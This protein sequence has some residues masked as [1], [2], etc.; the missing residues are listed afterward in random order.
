MSDENDE[1]YLLYLEESQEHL[2]DIESDLLEIEAQGEDLDDDLINRVFR[3]VHTVKGGAG[4]F[5]LTK[6]QSLAHIMENVLG[7]V[8]SKEVVVNSAMISAL[9]DGADKLKNMVNNPDIM[10][11]IE[12][13]DTIK[14]IENS[15]NADSGNSTEST[16]I[17]EEANST[18]STTIVFENDV[19]SVRVDNNEIFNMSKDAI[20]ASQRASTGG[21]FLYLV[22]Y[23]VK[24]D[25]ENKGK[26]L[27][28]VLKEYEILTD[29][30]DTYVETKELGTLESG[31]LESGTLESGTLE[32][33]TSQPITL[34][35]LFTTVMDSMILSEFAGV[36]EDK[37]NIVLEEWVKSNEDKTIEE[38]DIIVKEQQELGTPKEKSVGNEPQKS[39]SSEVTK[40]DVSPAA[41]ETPRSIK[42]D[43][44][45]ST[46]DPA[47]G[48]KKKKSSS[49]VRIPIGQLEVLMSLAGEL[50]LTRNELLQK[51]QKVESAN[52]HEIAQKVDSITSELQEAIMVTRMQSVDIVFNKF[53][54]VVRDLSSSLGKEIKLEIT[55]GDVEL[56][57]SIVEVI[58]DPLT[59]MVRNSID[60]GIEMPDVREANGKPREGTL[61]LS[62]MHKAG[63]VVISIKDDGG[64]IDPNKIGDIALSKGIITEE[65]RKTMTDKNLIMLI[66]KPGFSTAEKVTDLSGRGV[67]MDV[68]LSSFS[69][70]GGVVDIESEVGK[71]TEITIKLP[72]TLAIIPSLLIQVN[73]DRFAIPQVNVK[74]LVRIRAE[75]VKNRLEWVGNAAVLRLRGELLPVVRLSELLE[76][77]HYY[78]DKETGELKEDRRNRIVDRR[79]LSENE[80]PKEDEEKL[81]ERNNGRRKSKES[82]LNIVIVNAGSSNYGIVVDVLLDSEEI[83][84]KPLGTH[85]KGVKYYAGATILGDGHVAMI[86]DVASIYKNSIISSTIEKFDNKKEN[87]ESK[88]TDKEI[89]LLFRN[90][91]TNFSLP[92]I[93]IKRIEKVKKDDFVTIGNRR[94]IKY[95]GDT[96]VTLQI[97]DLCTVGEIGEQENYNVIIYQIGDREVGLVVGEVDDTITFNGN[98]DGETYVQPGIMGTFLNNNTIYYLVDFYELCRNLIPELVPGL[99]DSEVDTTKKILLVEDSKFFLDQITT[100][101]EG[102]GYSVITAMDGKEGIEK[103]DANSESIGM[104]VTD[105]EMPVMDGLEMV[106]AIREDGNYNDLPI[107]AVTSVAGEEAEKKGLEAGIDRYLIKM[108]KEQLLDTCVKFFNKKRG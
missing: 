101:L 98:F 74:E 15:L 16:A 40:K 78:Q 68:V 75:E 70:V 100:L 21:K 45:P 44:S 38:Q 25:I 59:H 48:E 22:E 37:I 30:I 53:K 33:G 83:V 1:V 60:H 32:S 107:I 41:T 24:E 71:G 18:E 95:R 4:F 89:L 63:Q 62:A 3:A 72:L 34:I 6:I 90:G 105:I 14:E 66:F 58:G 104:I 65:E 93:L 54:R 26:N 9:L 61:Q 106:K 92:M 10:D 31:T 39:Q 12:V 96:L 29:V 77:P 94:A 46:N 56:D 50:V 87:E 7:K 86:L 27:Q 8:R 69:K 79:T 17:N 49:T 43:T 102:V 81:R 23:D 82:A 88:K 35:L 99:S 47:N 67:G 55:G 19:L 51:V 64:G 97:D 13:D 80:V 28:D 85:L 2:E 84:V 36:A 73:N 42:K 5:S 57:R 91:D 76:M 108:D 103:L 11:S 52:I 20:S